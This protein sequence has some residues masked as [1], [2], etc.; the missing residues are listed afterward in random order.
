M[1]AFKGG[2]IAY[3]DSSDDGEESDVE[4]QEEMEAQL[5]QTYQSAAIKQH[6]G[7]LEHADSYTTYTGRLGEES[8]PV[9][10]MVD[11]ADRAKC[12]GLSTLV[13]G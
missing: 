2:E 5:R 6:A 3:I 1:F 7:H 4:N 9:S 11:R 8:I 12:R 13:S 10:V